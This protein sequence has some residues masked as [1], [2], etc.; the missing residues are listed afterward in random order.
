[1]KRILLVSHC[2]LNTA[3][4]LK[5]YD[6]KSASE[7]EG[8]RKEIVKAAIDC[9]VQLLQLP[10]PEFL[11]Y[12]SN[13]WGHT[14]N[15]FDNVF[16]RQRCRELLEP[17]VMQLMEYRSNPKEFEVIGV[18]GIDGSPSCGVK[19]TCKGD[20]GG[21]FGGRREVQKALDSCTLQSGQGVLMMVLEEMLHEK[22][23]S[24]KMEGLF[25]PEPQ[26]ALS[27]LS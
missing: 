8:L 26:R 6:E 15:Q 17:I 7:E 5:T 2:V 12:G 10:C 13:R 1:M 19:Y 25:A 24:L 4:K 14:Q 27:M 3:S 16:F 18:L 20:W 9:D 23:I 22:G 21:E 11:Q